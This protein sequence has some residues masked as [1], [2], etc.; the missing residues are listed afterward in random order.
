MS[1]NVR[2]IDIRLVVSRHRA[3][4]ILRLLAREELRGRTN[5]AVLSSLL[6]KW[7]LGG[8]HNVICTQIGVLEELGLVTVEAVDDL[9]VVDLTRQGHEVANGT[10]RAEGVEPYGPERLYGGP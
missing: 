3:L 10:T 9:L 6:D 1:R 2:T 5:D 7:G 4:A 8:S